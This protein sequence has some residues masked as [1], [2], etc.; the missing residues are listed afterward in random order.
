M[1]KEEENVNILHES[2]LSKKQTFVENPKL[3]I[4]FP[5]C[6]AVKQQ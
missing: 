4:F 3:T 1:T 5:S 2:N 6:D